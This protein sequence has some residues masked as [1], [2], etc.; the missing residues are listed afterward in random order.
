M[1]A[2]KVVATVAGTVALIDDLG[3][4]GGGPERTFPKICERWKCEALLTTKYAI[5]EFNLDRLVGMLFYEN[6]SSINVPNFASS[7]AKGYRDD[8]SKVL[9]F[10][11]I[12]DL[13]K[14]LRMAKNSRNISPVRGENISDKWGKSANSTR[15][16]V[17]D[18]LEIS[19]FDSFL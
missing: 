11:C 10:V 7:V 1:T 6:S 16:K 8:D 3:G 5:E 12:L 2:G 17:F 13:L 15:K 14:C 18:F 9:L 19:E 4:E